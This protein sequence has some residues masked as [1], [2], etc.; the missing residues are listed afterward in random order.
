MGPFPNSKGNKYILVAVDY[1]SK[2]VKAKAL[3][4]NDARVVV[5]F[6]K[7]LFSRFGTPKAIISDHGTHFCNDQFAKVMSKYGVTHRLSTAYTLKRAVGWRLITEVLLFNSRLKIFSRKLKTSW[8]GP[9][10]IT[11]VYPYGTAKL[12]HA[13][14]FKFQSQLS[15][16]EA[17]LWRGCTTDEDDSEGEPM[18]TQIVEHPIL[19][20]N[21]R[22]SIP[23]SR[24]HCNSKNR[25][26]CFVC[27]SLTYLIE[28]CDYYEKKM[29]QNPIKNH[30]MRGNNQ[31]YARI[32]HPNPQRHVVPITVLTRSMLVP[33]IAAKP[34]N[35]VVPQTKDHHQKPAT[36][37]VN[38][39]HSPKRRPI[40]LIPSP[41][42]SNFHQKVTTAKASQVN[43]VLGIKGN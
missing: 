4:T 20:G 7:S 43:V 8:S 26:A 15:S 39:A 9:F 1:L 5:K 3:P 25:K 14:R 28:N 16:F 18:P 32:T 37:G 13:D 33:L 19:A 29:V 6:L 42:A 41:P 21:L 30:A 24:G 2:W 35:T 40:N 12:A 27:K 38:K 10:T 17:L 11:K 36:H 34:V 22:K 31:H 23:K